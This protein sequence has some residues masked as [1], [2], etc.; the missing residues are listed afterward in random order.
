MKNEYI[1]KNGID[2]R[3]GLYIS[4]YYAQ[5]AAW[6]DEVVVKVMGGYRIMKVTD[7]IIWKKQK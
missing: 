4:R 7:Y 2:I 6:G 5:K 1:D 3:T